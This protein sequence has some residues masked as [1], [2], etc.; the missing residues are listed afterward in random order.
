[1]EDDLKKSLQQKTIKIK[2]KNATTQPISQNNLKQLLLESEDNL[3]FF[4]N[5]RPPQFF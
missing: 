4:E 1:M 3:N 5:G 2:A